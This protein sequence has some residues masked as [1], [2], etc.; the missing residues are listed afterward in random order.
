MTTAATTAGTR[1]ACGHGSSCTRCAPSPAASASVWPRMCSR[2]RE[3]TS[4]LIFTRTTPTRVMRCSPRHHPKSCARGPPWQ[5]LARKAL[6][7]IPLNHSHSQCGSAPVSNST[8]AARVRMVNVVRGSRS[9]HAARAYALETAAWDL[10][11]PRPHAMLLGN[12][13]RRRRAK[14]AIKMHARIT[15][16]RKHQCPASASLKGVLRLPV[17]QVLQPHQRVLRLH[18]REPSSLELRDS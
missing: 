17:L 5:H 12:V 10:P 8:L 7:D 16:A 6:A 2:E 15:S 13:P 9:L 18:L 11:A 4:A 3:Y 14:N 1:L